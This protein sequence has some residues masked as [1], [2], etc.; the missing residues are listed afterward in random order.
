[1][2][3]YGVELNEREN[4]LDKIKII[5]QSYLTKEE[6]LNFLTNLDFGYVREANF[7]LITGFYVEDDN[8][9]PLTKNIT[10]N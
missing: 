3:E 5:Q 9:K 6:L 10:F 2:Y 1:M 4:T 7:E 8:I